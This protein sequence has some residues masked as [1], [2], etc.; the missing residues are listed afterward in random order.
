MLATVLGLVLVVAAGFSCTKSSERDQNRPSYTENLKIPQKNL[1]RITT[2]PTNPDGG[3]V[4]GRIPEISPE[5]SIQRKLRNEVAPIEFGAG[6]GGI[7]MATT[8]DE[9]HAVLAKPTGMFNGLEIFPEDLRIRWSNQEPQTPSLFIVGSNYK[10]K[11]N[12]GGSMGSV[13]MQTPFEKF[14]VPNDAA[15]R[16]ALLKKIGS[17]FEGKDPASYD[18]EAAFTCRLDEDE[19]FLIFDF[20]KGGLLLSKAK[21]LSLDI[22]YFQP[23]RELRPFLRDPL[24]YRQS[25]AGITLASTKAATGARIGAA[26]SINN[27][28]HFYDDFN[29][30]VIWNAMNTPSLVYVR[31]GY[32]GKLTVTGATP[33]QRGFGDS[34]ADLAPTDTD[35]RGLMRALHRIYENPNQDC[36]AL[37][38]CTLISGDDEIEIQLANG[39]FGFSKDASRKLL[40]FGIGT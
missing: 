29:L 34:F 40:Y 4:A 27:G 17:A 16:T 7:T 6:A 30:I 36:V 38:T 3:L 21:Q 32:R 2:E 5:E 1:D 8:F 35:G 18:C 24:V 28:T 33:P 22:I 31:T 15:T 13:D 25:V 20:K 26:V 12:I 11:V 39:F 14:L 9:A 37:A 23:A 19:T 10:G